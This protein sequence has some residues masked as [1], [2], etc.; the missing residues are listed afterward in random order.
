[1][2]IIIMSSLTVGQ[3]VDII[4]Q[5]Y[6]KYNFDLP[7]G[8]QYIALSPVKDAGEIQGTDVIFYRMFREQAQE[9]GRY[10]ISNPLVQYPIRLHV[11]FL[12]PEI[13]QRVGH[14][15]TAKFDAE[16]M[17]M[18]QELNFVRQQIAECKEREQL[19]VNEL[20]SLGIEA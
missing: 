4:H 8:V 3:K 19:L 9:I 18:Q 13:Q 1:M 11:E 10:Y 20:L 14:V 15:G 6:M 2:E 16:T 5:A 7:T 17:R 12:S